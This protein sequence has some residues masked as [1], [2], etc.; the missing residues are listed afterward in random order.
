MSF[1][2]ISVTAESLPI[3][4][5]ISLNRIS[6]AFSVPGKE[7]WHVLGGNDRGVC[8]RTL[9][10]CPPEG[11]WSR[12]HCH[13]MAWRREGAALRSTG[14]CVASFLTPASW[15]FTP[16]TAASQAKNMK[17]STAQLN[18]ITPQGD[19]TISSSRSAFWEPGNVKV[20]SLR[21]CIYTIRGQ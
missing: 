15:L 11:I 17:N 21:N 10:P 8:S 20:S 4:K 3:Y 18:P 13:L 1:N 16:P 19:F 5:I 2:A 9:L 6:Y 12:Q 7:E 14:A